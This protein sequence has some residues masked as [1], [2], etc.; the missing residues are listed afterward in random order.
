MDKALVY[1]T[2]VYRSN[3]RVH[4]RDT[5]G[6]ETRDVVND[7]LNWQGSRARMDLFVSDPIQE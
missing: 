4:V 1:G 5:K 7:A 3:H 6:G 2:S